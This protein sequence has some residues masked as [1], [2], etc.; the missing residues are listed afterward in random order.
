MKTQTIYI[1]SPL[2]P[3]NFCFVCIN[4]TK[5]CKIYMR[6]MIKLSW[7]IPKM[8]WMN[9]YS[10]F[11]DRKTQYCQDSVLSRCQFLICKFSVI[12]IKIRESF[13]DFNKLILQFIWVGK[14][15]RITTISKTHKVGHQTL[16]NLKSY[17]KVTV[18]KT[19]M[20]KERAM[21]QE[22]T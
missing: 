2:L 1:N 18:L 16:P 15:P 20:A 9:R 8:K 4:L 19:D 21:K 14:R 13:V 5:L 7:R 12:S 17:Y 3:W 22:R 10:I 11:T 6:K